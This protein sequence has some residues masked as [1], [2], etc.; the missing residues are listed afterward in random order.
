VSDSTRP[1]AVGHSAGH[2][3]APDAPSVTLEE[4]RIVT[5]LREIAAALL[6]H[7]SGFTIHAYSDDPPKVAGECWIIIERD[8]NVGVIQ[9]DRLEGYKVLSEIQPSKE[10][11]SSLMV[12]LPAR[13]RTAGCPAVAERKPQ[14]LEELVEAAHIATRDSYSNFATLGRSM[15]ND[16]WKHF[17]WAAKNLVRI[18]MDVNR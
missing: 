5:E 17:D 1:L 9:Y 18:G 13:P 3:M 4:A 10:S 2:G 16:G 8:G 7:E 6:Q 12:L 15:R 11:G 14:A